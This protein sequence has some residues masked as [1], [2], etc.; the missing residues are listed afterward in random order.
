M[1]GQNIHLSWRK[2]PL[3]IH[4]LSL[5]PLL[6]RSASPGIPPTRSLNKLKSVPLK[7]RVCTSLL[8]FLIPSRIWDSAT[9]WSVWSWL[10]L[11]N[12]SSVASSMLVNTTSRLASALAGAG[13]AKSKQHPWFPA[14]SLSILWTTLWT[15]KYLIARHAYAASGHGSHQAQAKRKQQPCTGWLPS[16]KPTSLPEWLPSI[17]NLAHEHQ[18]LYSHSKTTSLKYRSRLN[19]RVSEPSYEVC[20][21]ILS[22]YHS[23]ASQ[24]L[25]EL[26]CMWISL[27]L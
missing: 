26:L 5:T 15:T 7:L 1:K 11:I 2:L 10:P 9:L 16:R 27:T 24:S 25:V 19:H 22:R 23:R 12:T 13:D 6:F 3:E 17:S 18:P 8:Y 14:H 4:H 20:K 21:R